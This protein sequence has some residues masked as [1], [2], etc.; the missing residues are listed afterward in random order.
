MKLSMNGLQPLLVDMS[1]NL[2]RRNV[3]MSEHLL[4]DP[5]IGA[6]AEKVRRKTVSEQ[7][8]IDVRFQAGMPRMLFHNLPDSRGR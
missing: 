2:R 3:G 6:V 1:V 5:E 4:D 8:R 7:M